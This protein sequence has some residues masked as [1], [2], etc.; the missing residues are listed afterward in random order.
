MTSGGGLRTGLSGLKAAGIVGA[1]LWLYPAGTDG[2][3]GIQA[4]SGNNGAYSFSDIAPG[5]YYISVR[6]EGYE[7]GAIKELAVIN[8]DVSKSITLQ[9][10]TTDGAGSAR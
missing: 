3:A 2:G 1:Q 7:P 6:A 4:Q 9:K 10:T 8:A 5:I